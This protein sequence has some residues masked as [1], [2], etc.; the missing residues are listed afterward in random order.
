[1][2]D[3]E[4]TGEVAAVVNDQILFFN[5]KGLLFK[6]IKL[7]EKILQISPVYW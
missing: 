4:K 7:E 2:A 6:E 1:M 5:D 3:S